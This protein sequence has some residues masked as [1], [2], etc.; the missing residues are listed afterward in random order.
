MG[1]GVVDVFASVVVGGLGA[2]GLGM[3]AFGV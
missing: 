1:A 3:W 2:L